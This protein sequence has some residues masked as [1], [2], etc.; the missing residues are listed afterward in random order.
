ME[1]VTAEAIN[2][3]NGNYN[4]SDTSLPFFLYLNP[5]IPHD[6]DVLDSLKSDC[7][8]TSGEPLKSYPQIKNMT[9]KDGVVKTCREYRDSVFK[10]LTDLLGEQVKL[11]IKEIILGLIWLDDR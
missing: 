7:L 10:R 3:I 1:W 8:L 5:T 11:N 2:F 4:N 9:V 6:P